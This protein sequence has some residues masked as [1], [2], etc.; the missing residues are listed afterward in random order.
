DQYGCGE[1]NSIAFECEKHAGL[2]IA[3]E[4]AIVELVNDSAEPVVNGSGRVVITDLDNYATPLIRYDNGDLATWRGGSCTCGRASPML[5]SIDGRAYELLSAP[6]NRK[7]HGGFFDEIYIE[8]GFG[9][10]YVIDD[11]RIVQEDLDSYRLE[12]VMEGKLSDVDVRAVE[13]KYRDY[14]G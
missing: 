10:R 2:H 6:G 11:L 9:D 3:C 1:S 13:E 4:H 8:L 12:F 7:I 14:L 5:H